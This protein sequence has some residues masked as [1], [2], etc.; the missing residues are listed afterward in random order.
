[1]ERKRVQNAP[2]IPIQIAQTVQFTNVAEAA[3][4]RKAGQ[5][6]D[7]RQDLGFRHGWTGDLTPVAGQVHLGW[8][9]GIF[10]S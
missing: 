7:L 5:R 10:L 8:H 3:A 1:V 6:Q 2:L 9:P 4:L